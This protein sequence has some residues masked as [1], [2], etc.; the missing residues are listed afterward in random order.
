[1]CSRFCRGQVLG[2]S[3]T[4]GVQ[5]VNFTGREVHTSDTR[6]GDGSSLEQLNVRQVTPSCGKQSDVLGNVTTVDRFGVAMGP[7]YMGVVGRLS[8]CIC[9]SGQDRGKVQLP[10]S[11]RGRLY[12][13]LECKF[14]SIGFF[15]IA[16]GAFGNRDGA[17]VAMGSFGK[18]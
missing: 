6:P 1:M 15:G 17:R 8:D 5:T 9:S 10:G 4:R 11:D 7:G 14:R 3:V 16:G 13:T 18:N 2:D 12:S